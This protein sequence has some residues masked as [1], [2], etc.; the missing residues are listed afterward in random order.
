MNWYRVTSL[1]P[2]VFGDGR[3][4]STDAGSQSVK[5]RALPPPGTVA[6]ALRTAKGH[7]LGQFE[8]EALRN[9]VAAGPLLEKDGAIQIPHPSDRVL[10]QKGTQPTF[11]RSVPDESLAPFMNLGDDLWPCVISE[12]EDIEPTK[13]DAPPFLELNAALDW[14]LKPLDS[15]AVARSDAP[16][17]DRA[18]VAVTPLATPMRE[19][20]VHVAIN[21]ATLASDAGKLFQTEG[22]HFTSH[23]DPKSRSSVSFSLRVGFG[24][25]LPQ[26][27]ALHLGGER[28]IALATKTDPVLD[29]HQRQRVATA[30]KDRLAVRLLLVTPAIFANGYRPA[31]T[32]V[33]GTSVEVVLRAIALGRRDFVSGW[34]FEKMEPKPVRY[35]VPAGSVLFFEVTN[36]NAEELASA[37]FEPVSDREQDRKDG[38]GLGLWGV[39]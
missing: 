6:G 23:L 13:G 16:E 39:W 7:S 19:R 24:E 12:D 27:F 5:S 21:A 22:V 37:M 3:P 28:R 36:G 26:D 33:P 31:W 14:L 17:A 1:D 34:D 38:Y 32:T 20:R 8:P 2:L 10:V 11:V 35:L 15:E 30:L 18:D 25:D 9:M 29:E 4:F